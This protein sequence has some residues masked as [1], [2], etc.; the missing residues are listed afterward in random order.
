MT[1]LAGT[2]IEGAQSRLG[3]KVGSDHALWTWVARH[4][5]R[6]PNRPQ[7]VKG[8]TPYELVYGKSSK[9]STKEKVAFVTYVLTDGVQ[10]VPGKS[11]IQRLQCIFMGVPNQL[12][13][14]NHS[15]QEKSRSITSSTDRHLENV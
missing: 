11:H 14:Q 3:I 9:A 2:F 5:S 8:A 13:R 1:K 10:V 12:W 15:H 6:V 7:Q 4:A